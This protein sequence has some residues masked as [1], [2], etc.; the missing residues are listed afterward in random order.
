[1]LQKKQDFF[2]CDGI[3][4]YL[5]AWGMFYKACQ[6]SKLLCLLIPFRSILPLV[7]II[8]IKTQFAHVISLNITILLCLTLS[9]WKPISCR[10]QSIDL[11]SKSMDWFL[12]DID[13]HHERVKICIIRLQQ[14]INFDFPIV[15]FNNELLIIRYCLM[16]FLKKS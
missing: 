1:M 13:L 16:T 5:F 4:L 9:W 8:L 2:Y 10:N 14:N 15:S 7:K 6:N 12:Y 11:Q 3:V